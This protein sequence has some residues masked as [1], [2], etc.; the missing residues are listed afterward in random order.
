MCLS[1][2]ATGWY[3]VSTAFL[4]HLRGESVQFFGLDAQRFQ[5]HAAHVFAVIAAFDR[6]ESTLPAFARHG[7]LD[8]KAAVWTPRMLVVAGATTA[9]AGGVRCV[10]RVFVKHW[11]VALRTIGWRVSPASH[12]DTHRTTKRSAETVR[13]FVAASR[14][15]RGIPPFVKHREVPGGTRTEIWRY[16]AVNLRCEPRGG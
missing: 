2:T 8:D 7:R 3:A 15:R 5:S 10:L 6:H 4:K 12:G 14:A 16:S 11:P 9:E 1:D 13:N